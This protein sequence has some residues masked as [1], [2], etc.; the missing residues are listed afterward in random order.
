MFVYPIIIA[1]NIMFVE[2]KLLYDDCFLYNWYT[3]VVYNNYLVLWQQIS[4]SYPNI[5]GRIHGILLT[6]RM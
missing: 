5:L 1:A 6:V 2:W 3:C 4:L